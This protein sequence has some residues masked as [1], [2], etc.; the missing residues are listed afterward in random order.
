MRKK[1][2]YLQKNIIVA[3]KH[4]SLVFIK[5][6]CDEIRYPVKVAPRDC[7]LMDY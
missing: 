3:C 5:C 4:V 6:T 2:S 7:L 1:I